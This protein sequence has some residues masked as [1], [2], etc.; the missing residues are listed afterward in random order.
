MLQTLRS[1]IDARHNFL[2]QARLS[3]LRQTGLN[4]SKIITS[5]L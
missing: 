4:L 5:G 3:L 2:A 1:K